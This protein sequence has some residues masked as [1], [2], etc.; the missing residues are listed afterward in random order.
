MG[1]NFP[2]FP[3]DALRFLLD[4]RAN[5]N[6]PW[7]EANKA[8]Y[9]ASLLEPSRAFVIAMGERLRSIAPGIHAEPQVNRSLFR[10]NRDTRFSADKSP[11]KTEVGIFFW[12]G[13]RDRM[14]CPGFYMHL[15]PGELMLG[16]GLYLFPPELLARYRDACVHPQSGATLRQA[17]EQIRAALGQQ[18]LEAKACGGNVD[19]LKRVPAGYD[20]SHPNAEF[21]KYKGLHAGVGGSIPAAFHTPDFVDQAFERFS[22]MMPLH[23][24]LV[25][26]L[27]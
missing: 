2:G 6:K 25:E 22:A 9:E 4:L 8:R 11:Y 23:R 24:W 14:A 10:I 21:L 26:N 17:V 1:E 16:V 27:G 7:F 5:N 12:E 15:E 3:E 19:H 20:D 18:A 13:E